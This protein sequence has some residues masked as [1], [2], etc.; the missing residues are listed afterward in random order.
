MNSPQ[1]KIVT[2]Y[3][4]LASFWTFGAE[5]WSAVRDGYEPPDSDGVG[6]GNVGIGRTKDEAIADLLEQE[7]DA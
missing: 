1:P 3:S 2:S 4:D 6:G 5:A 7:G